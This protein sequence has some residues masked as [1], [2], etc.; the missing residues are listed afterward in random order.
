M[1]LNVALDKTGPTVIIEIC[2]GF[3]SN[4]LCTGGSKTQV[5]VHVTVLQRNKQHQNCLLALI[6]RQKCCFRSKGNVW[7]SYLSLEQRLQ[8]LTF[9]I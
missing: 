2:F 3:P 4:V 9:V 8:V 7:L 6:T 5:S 1:L